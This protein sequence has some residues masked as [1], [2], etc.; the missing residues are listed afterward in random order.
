MLTSLSR[1]PGPAHAGRTTAGQAPAGPLR[2]WLLVPGSRMATR[3]ALARAQ[4]RCIPPIVD[5]WLDEY[6]DEQYDG[7][8]GIKHY[9]SHRSIARMSRVLGDSF[10]QRNAKLLRTFR[11]V[12]SRTGQKL[13]CG[14]LYKRVRRR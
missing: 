4:Q 3:H 1:G 8:G 6:G 11:V 13:T 5:E 9:F 2:E 10:I 14:W 12:D 7:H